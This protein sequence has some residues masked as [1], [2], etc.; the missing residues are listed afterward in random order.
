MNAIILFSHGSVLCGSGLALDAHAKRLQQRGLAPR[1]AVGYL[2]Y[3]EPP[4]A[5]TVARCVAEGAHRILVAPYFLIPGYFVK[6][7]LP[8]A[9]DAARARFPEIE[10][11]VAEALGYDDR[12]TDAILTSAQSAL[13]TAFWREDLRR[14]SLSCRIN[15]QCPL[16]DTPECPGKPAS[17]ASA[18]NLKSVGHIPH[19]AD[20]VGTEALLFLVHG[21]PRPIA[22]TDMFR[23]AEAIRARNMYAHVEVGFLECNEP[24]IPSA[25]DRCAAA[26]VSRIRAVP[27]FLHTGTHV[28]EDLP[29]LLESAQL[30][31]PHLEFLLG[32]YLGRSELLTDI[33]A[34]RIDQARPYAAE[35]TP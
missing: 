21:S 24:D 33:L 29:T 25:I 20:P 10:F 13:S 22:N 5:E 7:D 18:S 27:Y 8:K 12:L 32:D 6:V 31:Y 16:F 1:V 2:N 15:P 11:Q 19:T 23:V 26:G 14:A 3:S 4:F 30:R 35:Q 34:D 9:L 17:P 28:A